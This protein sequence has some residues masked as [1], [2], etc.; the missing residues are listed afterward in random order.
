MLAAPCNPIHQ[1]LEMELG[2][3]RHDHVPE[4]CQELK[5]VQAALAVDIESIKQTAQDLRNAMY[6]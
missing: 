5:V 3:R 4:E 2:Y 6:V 1:H